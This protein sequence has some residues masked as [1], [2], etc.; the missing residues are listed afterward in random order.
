MGQRRLTRPGHNHHELEICFSSYSPES[1]LGTIGKRCVSGYSGHELL[2]KGMERQTWSFRC[3]KV[4]PCYRQH[5]KKR[6]GSGRTPSAKSRLLI[7]GIIVIPMDPHTK[8][9]EKVG[10][11]VFVHLSKE[12]IS[13]CCLEYDAA[14]ADFRVLGD[15]LACSSGGEREARVTVY[16][17]QYWQQV[18]FDIE[19]RLSKAI[20]SHLRP[21]K[22]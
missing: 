22:L 16:G 18:K 13:F 19:K 9:E 14:L 3:V 17:T 10:A 21:S 2:N 12:S 5:P 4:L 8:I 15:S 20:P 6:L 1:L 7:L 11:A